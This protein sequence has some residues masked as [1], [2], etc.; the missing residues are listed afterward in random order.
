MLFY[1]SKNPKNQN[2]AELKKM[3]GDIII[4]H[5]RTK[6]N[7]HMM[8]G[9]C[10]MEWDRQNFLSFWDIFCHF[11]LLATRKIKILKKKLSV[12]IKLLILLVYT[13]GPQMTIIS[14]MVPEIWSTTDRIFCHFGP[15]LPFYPTNN[16][17]NQDFHKNFK[18]HLEILSFY[19]CVT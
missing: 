16:P 3:A 15:F 8:Y 4:L 14:C 10:D 5:M 19:K 6:N 9:P 1:P 2:F 13:S 18:R 11:T 12:I 7:N 17:Q